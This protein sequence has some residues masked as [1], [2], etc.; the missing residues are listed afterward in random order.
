[1]LWSEAAEV[2]AVG[3]VLVRRD[4]QGYPHAQ[5]RVIL[6][7]P[8]AESLCR[9]LQERLQGSGLIAEQVVVREDE[10]IRWEADEGSVAVLRMRLLLLEQVLA[11]VAARWEASST[12]RPSDDV[13]E[14][15][16]SLRVDTSLMAVARD[17]RAML[18]QVILRTARAIIARVL[19]SDAAVGGGR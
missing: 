5:E 12:L 16:L 2:R 11:A 7:T 13:L 15:G 17:P 1:M 19:P 9:W 14:L 4:P 10:A 6:R 8:R 3:A 18:E